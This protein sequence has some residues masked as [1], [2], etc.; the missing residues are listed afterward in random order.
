M[1]MKNAS[2]HRLGVGSILDVAWVDRALATIRAH[3]SPNF[4]GLVST[5]YAGDRP[6]AAHMGMRSS[7]TI[8]WWFNTYDYDL[9]A[10]APGLALLLMLAKR[11]AGD[12]LKIIDF[13]RGTED[14]KLTFS[15][16]STELCEGSIERPNS[17]PGT[18]RRFQKLGVRAFARV[19]LGRY[20]S[21]PRRALHRFVTSMSLPDEAA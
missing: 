6:V 17:L 5:L 9:R 3:R 11:A 2:Y 12:G 7:T 21:L 20:E 1:A 15:N 8:H 13:G 10:Y 16:G 4:A 19:P 18:V 14:Y